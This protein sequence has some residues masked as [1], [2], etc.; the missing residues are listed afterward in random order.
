[1]FKKQ[2]QSL[3]LDI[4]TENFFSIVEKDNTCIDSE[5]KKTWIKEKPQLFTDIDKKIRKKFNIEPSLKFVVSLYKPNSE[6]KSLVIKNSINNSF[7]NIIISSI[8]DKVTFKDEKESSQINIKKWTAYYPFI[9]LSNSYNY[10]FLN[11]NQYSTSA[12]KGHRSVKKVRNYNNRYVLKFDYILD[13][14]S[15]MDFT[16]KLFPK[17]KEEKKSINISKDDYNEA[18]KNLNIF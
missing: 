15:F 12:K 13:N 4:D 17:E 16:Q 14:K 1:M 10:E 9:F 6:K 18:L 7:I 5:E 3:P 2:I 8:D 11:T